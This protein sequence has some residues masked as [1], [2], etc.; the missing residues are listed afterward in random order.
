MKSLT[1]KKYER[2]EARELELRLEATILSGDMED[3]VDPG[4]EIDF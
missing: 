3:P 1:L 4:Q 2:P